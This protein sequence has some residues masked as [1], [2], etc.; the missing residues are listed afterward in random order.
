MQKGDAKRIARLIPGLKLKKRKNVG[1]I[2]KLEKKA[3]PKKT[4]NKSM[5]NK[6]DAATEKADK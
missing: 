6:V 5:V 3:E 4:V 2:K 1:I